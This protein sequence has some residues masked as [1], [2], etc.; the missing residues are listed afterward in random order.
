MEHSSVAICN[1]LQPPMY[2]LHPTVYR[3]AVT[4]GETHTTC[5]EVISCD[6]YYELYSQ[7]R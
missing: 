5:A 1:T 7:D 2:S 4:V 6:Y 3:F